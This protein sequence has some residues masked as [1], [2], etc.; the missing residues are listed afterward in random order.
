MRRKGG[1]VGLDNRGAEMGRREDAK[2][3][4]ALL[5]MLIR[6]PLEEKR[7]KATPSTPA[8]R[9][10]DEKPL[11]AGALVRQLA[12]VINHFFSA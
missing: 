8:C 2:I 3:E 1:V 12:D 9:V 6:Q 5:T 4:L 11:K 10:E 7:S